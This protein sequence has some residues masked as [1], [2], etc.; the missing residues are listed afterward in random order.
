MWDTGSSPGV[1]LTE[2]YLYEAHFMRAYMAEAD[3]RG[4]TCAV[5]TFAQRPLKERALMG[6]TCAGQ[7]SRELSCEEQGFEGHT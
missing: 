5:W 4:R 6:R 1:D 3:F 7:L 2:A